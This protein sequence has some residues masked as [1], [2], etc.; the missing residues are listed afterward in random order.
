MSLKTIPTIHQ[1]FHKQHITTRWRDN[2]V[3]GHVNNVVYYSWFDTVVNG[4]LLEQNVLDFKDGEV[5]GLVV[6]TQCNYFKPVAYPDKI[7]AALA[8]TKVGNSSV[9]YEIG[10]FNGDEPDASAAGHF[11][12]VYVDAVSHKPVPVPGKLRTVLAKI[13]R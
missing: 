2:D 1:F 4:Y 7:T 6:E 13:Q 11:V 5:V 12:H 10:I 8:V 9:R 3:Y